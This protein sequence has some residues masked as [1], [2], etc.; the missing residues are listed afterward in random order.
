LKAFTNGTVT[1]TASAFN[2]SSIK[3]NKIINISGQS[4]S[5]VSP[6]SIIVYGGTGNIITLDKLPINMFVDVLPTITTNKGVAWSVLDDD[7]NF[8]L[9]SIATTTGFGPS[10]GVLT[11]A[12]NGVVTVVAT[13]IANP[14]IIGRAVVTITGQIVPVVGFS[15]SGAGGVKTLNTNK[16]SL[17]LTPT[18][19]PSNPS[20]NRVTWFIASSSN[21]LHQ[22][23]DISA[24]G[25]YTPYANGIVTIA[26]RPNGGPSSLTGIWVVTVTNQSIRTISVS[27]A[28]GNI[29]SITGVTLGL[30]GVA[31]TTLRVT[32][33]PTNAVNTTVGWSI[34]VSSTSE[35]TIKD[36]SFDSREVF[37][38]KS[39]DLVLRVASS[40][41]PS[42]FVLYTVATRFPIEITGPSTMTGAS[43]A[44]S[45]TSLFGFSFTGQ[46][47]NTSTMATSWTVEPTTAAS[48]VQE[49]GDSYANPSVTSSFDETITLTGFLVELPNVRASKII[50]AYLPSRVAPQNIDS[51]RFY[52]I[53]D[54][55][56]EFDATNTI[57]G[58]NSS[59][60]IQ[61]LFSPVRTSLL[62]INWALSANDII[63]IDVTNGYVT[64]LK[65]GVVT[66]TVTSSFNN[67]AYY[68]FDVQVVASTGL[69]SNNIENAVNI[70]P[71]PANDKIHIAV[72]SALQINSIYIVNSIGQVVLK[73]VFNNSS[74]STII[75]TTNL[76]KGVYS[77]LVNTTKGLIKKNIVVE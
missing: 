33:G 11:P 17:Q 27:P 51:V 1:V 48:V 54:E 7:P 73:K 16:Q 5:S 57:N 77:V 29:D 13:S 10:V 58:V 59:V 76:P 6:T 37:A 44:L 61:P 34:D 18:F 52:N 19:F 63:S 53:N 2:N 74:D 64:A 15:I 22:S 72:A 62:D 23:T 70:Y 4:A 30:T 41:D 26:G 36:I 55:G 14:S 50:Y 12:F 38:T 56:I 60:Y 9:A 28:P 42:V 32:V 46:N 35:G 67:S 71:N 21:G 69:T 3:G 75:Y 40:V 8:T 31:S 43:N 45:V 39:G 68:I 66:I 25:L 49:G 24:T 65:P 20:D 47:A